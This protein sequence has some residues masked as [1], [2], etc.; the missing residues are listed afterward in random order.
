MSKKDQ[1]FEEAYAELEK[2]A[3]EIDSG[4]M[5]LDESLKKFEEGAALA[6]FCKKKLDDAENK[7]VDIKKKFALG[8]I[9]EEDNVF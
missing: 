9:K 5:P 8:D 3:S 6:E 4:K 2:I 1:T 7:V